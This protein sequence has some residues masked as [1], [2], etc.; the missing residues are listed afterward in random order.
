MIEGAE[1][2]RRGEVRRGQFKA[3]AKR[4][5]RNRY[6]KDMNERQKD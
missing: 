6:K 3:K 1:R 4:K 5:N 2:P